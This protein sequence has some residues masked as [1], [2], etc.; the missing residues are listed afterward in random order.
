MSHQPFETWLLSNDPLNEE[1]QELLDSHL[2]ECKNC[3]TLSTALEQVDD[4]LLNDTFT[5]APQAG[6]VQRWHSRLSIARQ[7]RQQRKWWFLTIGLFGVTSVLLLIIFLMNINQINWFYEIGQVFA[8]FSRFASNI[9]QVINVIKSITSEFPILIPPMI[10]F[11]V[12]MLSAMSALVVTW[13]SSM[14]KL[15]KPSQKGVS[16][17]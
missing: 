7:Q 12:G 4:I 15:Y 11:G 1:Q 13:F 14:I 2:S 5:P 9:N 10:I 16:V 3:A 17:R 8:N 6:F